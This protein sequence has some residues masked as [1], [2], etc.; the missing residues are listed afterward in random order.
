MWVKFLSWQE[1]ESFTALTVLGW[2]G[3]VG[4][5]VVWEEAILRNFILLDTFLETL[6]AGIKLEQHF[7]L[8]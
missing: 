6:R 8:C 4:V 5:E 3:G 1:K 7:L 2:G